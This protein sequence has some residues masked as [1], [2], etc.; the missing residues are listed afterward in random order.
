MLATSAPLLEQFSLTSRL[1]KSALSQTLAICVQ[2][3]SPP[4][5]HLAPILT[6]IAVDHV[7]KLP[8]IVFIDLHLLA[9]H[10][11]RY[12]SVNLGLEHRENT[13][14]DTWWIDELLIDIDTMSLFFISLMLMIRDKEGAAI[15]IT[16]HGT[17]NGG[18][19]YY[20]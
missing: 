12:S 16:A 9:L 3:P 7:A 6:L 2:A 5:P 14:D 4:C 13:D 20:R 19:K 8:H 1:W 15:Y 10:K 18:G 11:C 17:G